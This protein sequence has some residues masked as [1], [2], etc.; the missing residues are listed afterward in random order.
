MVVIA[1]RPGLRV[2][3]AQLEC[4]AGDLAANV[5]AHVPLVERA[6]A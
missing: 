6:A 3:G 4:V 2:A 1:S 5:T